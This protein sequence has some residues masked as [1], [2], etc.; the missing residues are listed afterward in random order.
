MNIT[1]A[2]SSQPGWF[3]SRTLAA[4]LVLGSVSQAQN[5]QHLSITQPGGLPGLP[6]MTG[7][8]RSSN[9]WIVTWD[10]PP[11]YYQ[12]LEKQSWR[13][14]TW[15]AVGG[16]TNLARRASIST[17]SSNTFFKVLGPAPHYGGTQL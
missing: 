2:L 7:I 4:F 15:Q 8:E 16:R 6:V 17:L 11:G 12:L 10:G 3:F 13:N 1:K 14:S 5:V 9:H